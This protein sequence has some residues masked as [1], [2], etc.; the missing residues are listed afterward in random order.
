MQ[1]NSQPLVFLVFAFSQNDGAPPARTNAMLDVR[2]SAPRDQRSDRPSQSSQPHQSLRYFLNGTTG[3]SGGLFGSSLSPPFA[4]LE[5]SIREV[6][7]N[8]RT[9]LR[10]LKNG[11]ICTYRPDGLLPRKS[12]I[13]FQ[14][15]SFP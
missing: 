9:K 4:H 12:E 3:T 8:F 6:S 14:S 10:A 7:F 15:F 5:Y 1:G 13:P 2:R 11:H